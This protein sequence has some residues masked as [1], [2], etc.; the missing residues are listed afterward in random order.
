MQKNILSKLEVLYSATNGTFHA[1]N[2]GVLYCLHSV[3]TNAFIILHT[4]VEV[5]EKE[6]VAYDE[7]VE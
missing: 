3:L 5:D 2:F 1:P 4:E 6:E 7:T